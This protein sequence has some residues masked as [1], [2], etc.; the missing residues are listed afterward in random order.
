VAVSLH[1]NLL[2]R[3]GI[4]TLDD[5][6]SLPQLIYP[7]H[8]QFVDFDW[9]RLERYLTRKSQEHSSL[10]IAAAHEHATSMA[11]LQPHLRRNGVFNPNRFLKPSRLNDKIVRALYSWVQTF[12]EGRERSSQ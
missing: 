6:I 3:H 4:L 1:S 12:Q 7:K 11:R 10:Q 5:F 8:L 2:H 9:S